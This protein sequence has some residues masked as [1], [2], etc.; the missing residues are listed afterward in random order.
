MEKETQSNRRT[1][2]RKASTVAGLTAAANVL[3]FSASLRAMGA[4]DHINIGF[5][6]VGGRGGALV[7]ELLQLQDRCKIVA[8]CDVWERRKNAAAKRCEAEGY[9][10]YRELLDRNDIDAVFI[11]TPD[12]WHAKM[13][14]DAMKSGRDVYCE[15]PMTKTVDEAKKVY[16]TSVKT[17]RIMQVG[18]QYAS[19]DMNWEARRLIAEGRIGKLVWSQGTY[20]RNSREWEWNWAI[21]ENAG[22]TKAG[23]DHIDWNL[24]LGAAPKTDYDA[25]RYFRFR[26]FWDYSGGIATDLFYHKLAALTV[27]CGDEFPYRVTGTGGIWVQP[28][29]EVPDTFFTNIDYPSEHSINMPCSMASNI[30]VPTIIRGNYGTIYPDDPE[31]G[32]LRMVA[33]EPFKKEF[34]QL[35]GKEEFVYESKPREGHVENFLSCVKTRKQPNLNAR[36]AYIIMVPIAMS[37]E[38]YRKNEVLFFDSKKERVSARPVK[39]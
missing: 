12:H 22:P 3:P 13:S 38:A 18:S 6:G 17:D 8:V 26:K 36:R 29:R 11:A 5:I 35:N 15:K 30:G 4:N 7:S 24:W 2:L 25:E 23:D 37:V 31:P 20:C 9:T 39:I 14:I 10:D 21:D 1:F 34:V 33:E 32:H 27:C 19:L 16:E 28:D